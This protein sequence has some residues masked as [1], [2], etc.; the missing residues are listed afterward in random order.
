[1]EPIKRMSDEEIQAQAAN[2][3]RQ[4]PVG[5][6]QKRPRDKRPRLK[7]P[8]E[9]NPCQE[10]SRKAGACVGKPENIHALDNPHLMNELLSRS[11]QRRLMS[12]E[13]YV[14]A[15]GSEK[16]ET[17]P[18][19]QPHKPDLDLKRTLSKQL[20][21]VNELSKKYQKSRP[22]SA[23]TESLTGGGVGKSDTSTTTDGCGDDCVAVQQHH[24]NDEAV[25]R[26]CEDFVDVAGASGGKDVPDDDCNSIPEELS[27]SEHSSWLVSRGV[28]PAE[29]V[30]SDEALM[31]LSLH[32]FTSG[33]RA[34]NSVLGNVMIDVVTLR[35]LGLESL[36]AEITQARKV[37][38]ELYEAKVEDILSGRR[39]V[40]IKGFCGS[41][42]SLLCLYEDTGLQYQQQQRNSMKRKLDSEDEEWIELDVSSFTAKSDDQSD[43]DGEDQ[44]SSFSDLRDGDH[45]PGKVQVD[46]QTDESPPPPKSQPIDSQQNTPSMTK[47]ESKNK[48][49]AQ[50]LCSRGESPRPEKIITQDSGR[51]GQ[52]STRDEETITPSPRDGPTDKSSS[53]DRKRNKA[54]PCD[55]ATN[56]PWSDR[57]PGKHSPNNNPSAQHC[58]DA[59]KASNTS[60]EREVE[61]IHSQHNANETKLS[62]MSQ[63][64]R[65]FDTK[66]Q[67]KAPSK[68]SRC[69]PSKENPQCGKKNTA[70]CSIGLQTTIQIE[71]SGNDAKPSPHDASHSAQ[72]DG[73]SHGVTMESDEHLHDSSRLSLKGSHQA[74]SD[75]SISVATKHTAEDSQ[76]SDLTN[77]APVQD[78]HDKHAMGHTQHHVHD[79][80][81]LQPKHANH[82][83][84]T[85]TS[86]EAGG[87]NSAHP[88]ETSGSVVNTSD[89]ICKAY[90][91]CSAKDDYTEVD[92]SLQEDNARDINHINIESS[93]SCGEMEKP[94]AV[95]K[96]KCKQ[97]KC[98]PP[99]DNET[100]DT[101]STKNITFL[102]QQH[103]I[104]INGGTDFSSNNHKTN[105]EEQK[106]N[107]MQKVAEIEGMLDQLMLEREDLASKCSS[108]E[109]EMLLGEAQLKSLGNRMAILTS[110]GCAKAER[111]GTARQADEESQR[112]VDRV[113]E[114]LEETASQVQKQK[115]QVESLTSDIEEFQLQLNLNVSEEEWRE[116]RDQ[117][118]VQ[119][120]RRVS[121]LESKTLACADIEARYKENVAA[122]QQQV[123]EMKQL[124]LNQTV[125]QKSNEQLRE[126]I[127][128]TKKESTKRIHAMSEDLVDM[129]MT[130]AKLTNSLQ[131]AKDAKEKAQQKIR[132]KTLKMA[133]AENLCDTVIINIREDLTDNDK[134]VADL[135]ACGSTMP[136]KLSTGAA[137]YSNDTFSGSSAKAST[138]SSKTSTSS[139][140]RSPSGNRL[141]SIS[142]SQLSSSST[143][144]TTSST[145]TMRGSAVSTA[146]DGIRSLKA[147]IHSALTDSAQLLKSD[148]DDIE[149]DL[150][151]E[152]IDEIDDSTDVG[153]F[154][155]RPA[156]LSGAWDADRELHR[157]HLNE[158]LQH[159][160]VLLKMKFEVCLTF[161]S[162]LKKRQPYTGQKDT[163][164]MLKNMFSWVF[165]DIPPREEYTEK[166]GEAR[167]KIKRIKEKTEQV[168]ERLDNDYSKLMGQITALQAQQGILKQQ[169]DDKTKCYNML[170][171]KYAEVRTRLQRSLT[172]NQISL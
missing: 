169:L 162:D 130:N 24:T 15:A 34:C 30:A 116:D 28:S 109:L 111:D 107:L 75:E 54:S 48:E 100:E 101:E 117:E 163:V 122:L 20:L 132:D 140:K 66:S 159:L 46:V 62:V 31:E 18:E 64:S 124:R 155:R 144:S 61:L 96:Q 142:G 70:A 56:T 69:A 137:N 53:P 59:D 141:L 38:E 147:V 5:S 119:L 17:T 135:I 37:S 41:L 94:E 16:T 128:L 52:Q 113:K 106:H 151:V 55:R 23:A 154:S 143:K 125:M 25:G 36:A 160:D 4:S 123:D 108:T 166:I 65:S 76:A 57:R 95:D 139:T 165:E 8:T 105:L 86:T 26:K 138:S 80:Y 121:E 89:N 161:I 134:E 49:E 97:E 22:Q 115:D 33:N 98:R 60:P 104:T 150:V 88:N 21:K 40:E 92:C 156:P 42:D 84:I 9:E 91:A 158:A 87:E 78:L 74:I 47:Y 99:S 146:I 145:S 44:P 172:H 168:R 63:R 127:K 1:M 157:E 114:R 71:C 14:A 19:P 136:D 12:M 73:T 83:C 27:V 112:S 77:N 171:E 2:V 102:W 72:D 164:K 45:A 129:Q 51:S 32:Q 13:G 11:S 7:A 110:P 29:D 120:K 103:Y 126:E 79:Q 3:H 39:A 148:D 152:E 131:Q 58:Q 50:L 149:E 133:E 68:P 82:D 10:A 6:L 85:S 153:S 118:L 43:D 170:K 81:D 167:E 90:S 35:S 67:C 93:T